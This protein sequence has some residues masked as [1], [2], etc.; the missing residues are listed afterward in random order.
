VSGIGRFW[1]LP[2][3]IAMLAAAALLAVEAHA[4]LS[5]RAANERDATRGLLA[6]T[7]DKPVRGTSAAIGARE[8]SLLGLE[9]V[10]AL[11]RA[12][13]EIAH[14]RTAKKSEEAKR[15]LTEAQ[16]TLRGVVQGRASAETRSH[17]ANL[18]GAL[19]L[20]QGVT[21]QKKQKVSEA[22]TFFRR[23]VV[24]GPENESAKFNLEL[25][26]SIPGNEGEPSRQ[27]QDAPAG[28][29]YDAPG[30]GY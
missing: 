4:L 12:L 23:A 16:Q 30:T 25:V 15:A 2:V 27:T 1:R 8:R 6:L 11:H 13:D 17:A 24:L 14:S 22:T 3:A 5:A 26:L 9:G 7:S 29:G 19:L 10:P 18:L 20:V 28:V 21:Q